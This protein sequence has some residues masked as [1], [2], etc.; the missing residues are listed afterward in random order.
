MTAT[1][2]STK[3]VPIPRPRP[4]RSWR[5]LRLAVPFTVV[6]LFWTATGVVHYLEEP[7]RSDPGTL[8]PTGTGRHGS[9]QLAER[10]RD[11]G[12]TIARVTS[13]RA[14]ADAA[15]SGDAT[16]FVPTPDYLLPGFLQAWL[17][18][19]N[20]NNR[21][22]LVQPGLL[23]TAQLGEPIGI[24]TSRWAT[25]VA[26]PNCAT[27]YAQAA[28][29]AGVR[30]D[31]YQADR[32]TTRCYG[33]SLIGLTE[34]S[35]EVVYIGATDPFRNDRIGEHGNA[36][37]A[38]GLL[39]AHPR[40]IWVDVHAA[41]PRDRGSFNFSLPDYHRDDQ[42][43]TSTGNDLIDAFPAALWAVL[44]VLGVGAVLFAA[45]RSRRLGPPV[46]EPLPV[47]VPAAEAVTGRGRL[48]QRIRARQASLDALR[49]A[50]IA[51]LARVLDPATGAA[52]ERELGQPGPA[53]DRF[54]DLVAARTGWA[55]SQVYDVLYGHSPDSDEE[56]VDAAA[57][58]DLLVQNVISP[59]TTQ[60]TQ[61]GAP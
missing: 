9:S 34:G 20:G 13:S 14:A 35:A 1:L 39:T 30:H 10:L 6:V 33:G 42:D 55:P 40:V 25:G 27:D 29:P 44:L 2:P 26:D 19:S 21:I 11:K 24:R 38:T 7:T 53:A 52:A 22:V 58:L 8:S 23:T 17:T 54:V 46:P 59:R 18:E 32:P 41:E 31:I 4:A 51:R 47:L 56:L 37:L 12:V 5:W 50:A 61:G 28:G 36:A 45:A 16:I 43:R 15:R 48:Y 60:D 3:D 49:M 57:A